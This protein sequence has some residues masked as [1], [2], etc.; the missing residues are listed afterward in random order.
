MR[1]AHNLDLLRLALNNFDLEE[2]IDRDPL[3]FLSCSL[4]LLIPSFALYLLCVS[5]D[6]DRTLIFLI[7]IYLIVVV[8]VIVFIVCSVPFIV[9]VVLCVVFC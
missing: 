9:C 5:V 6:I 4:N 2:L 8:V 1:S 7:L 3:T